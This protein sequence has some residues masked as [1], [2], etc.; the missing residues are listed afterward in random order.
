MVDMSP[1]KRSQ[2]MKAIKSVSKLE[3]RVSRALWDKGFRFRKNS[4]LFG[5]PD[6]SIQKNKIVIFIDSCFWHVCPLHSN[7]PKSDQEYW[8]KK[9]TRNLVRD[10]EVNQYYLK[11]GWNI[12][13]VWE[14]ELKDD[15][16]ST[17]D[18]L[19]LFDD[20]HS[21]VPPLT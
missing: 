9:L 2:T 17:I 16:S 11:A 3:N 1:E 21:N 7:M 5:K 15:F 18:K 20:G 14:H 8:L 12:L 6:I 10:K 4:K 13:R 19:A